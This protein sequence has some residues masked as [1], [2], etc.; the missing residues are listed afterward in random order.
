MSGLWGFEPKKREKGFLIYNSR[1]LRDIQRGFEMNL[2][3]FEMDSK[4]D[5]EEFKE[6]RKGIF[7]QLL[8]REKIGDFP[9]FAKMI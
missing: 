1:R 2:L 4:R 9:T 8:A 7:F 3:Q 5:R 6:R